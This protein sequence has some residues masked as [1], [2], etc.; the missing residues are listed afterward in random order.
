MNGDISKWIIGILV[1]VLF[2]LVAF[3]WSDQ[4]A[5]MMEIQQQLHEQ[6]RRIAIFERRIWWYDRALYH[7]N[8]PGFL[9][10]RPDDP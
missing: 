8:A 4:R 6:E 3:I 1:A 2:S 9:K 10:L 7:L 5:D